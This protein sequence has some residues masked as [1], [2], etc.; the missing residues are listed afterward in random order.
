MSLCFMRKLFSR[1]FTF[2]HVKLKG[3]EGLGTRLK[4][5]CNVV[6]LSISAMMVHVITAGK[7]L[8]VYS[9]TNQKR[10]TLSENCA[11][12]F[13]T[14]PSQMKLHL[15][16]IF[17]HLSDFFPYKVLLARSL[18]SGVPSTLLVQ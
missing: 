7:Q 2:L 15:Y 8:K 6:V 4:E 5:V 10:K 18:A 14:S 1:A 3:W 12:H 9:L 17:T 16:E 13:T 11:G